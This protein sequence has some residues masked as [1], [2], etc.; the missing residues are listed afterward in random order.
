MNEWMNGVLGRLGAHVG[1]TG[2]G[3][4][5]ELTHFAMWLPHPDSDATWFGSG[6][7]KPFFES[8]L[9]QRKESNASEDSYGCTYE[10]IDPRSR[11]FE[12]INICRGREWK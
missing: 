10:F 12:D 8:E 5:R 1:K 6:G 4:T 3:G 9:N 2:P 11:P 7:D